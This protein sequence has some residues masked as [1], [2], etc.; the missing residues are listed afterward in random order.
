[1]LQ[2][3]DPKVDPYGTILIGN[4]TQ[5]GRER[6]GATDANGITP[7]GIDYRLTV[8]FQAYGP[9]ARSKVQQ[10]AA[11]FNYPSVGISFLEVGLAIVEQPRVL[12]IP[13]IRNTSWEE[14]AL[15][16]ATFHLADTN[17]DNTGAIEI[18]TDMEGN[19]LNPDGTTAVQ[20]TSTIDAS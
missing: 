6:Y 15:V 18:V 16:T 14:S 20:I 17:D 7:I 13:K 4:L 3:Q 8:D 5:V 19:Y 10:L 1:M 11:A 12:D 9:D 2:L